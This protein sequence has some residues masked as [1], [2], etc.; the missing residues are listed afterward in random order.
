[1]AQLNES[2][3]SIRTSSSSWNTIQPM[4]FRSIYSF[5]LIT[6][7][8]LPHTSKGI[9]VPIPSIFWGITHTWVMAH[10]SRPSVRTLSSSW[11]SQTT[12]F[13]PILSFLVILE[14]CHS[15]WYGV[16]LVSRIDLSIGLFWKEP[17]KK[18]ILSLLVI[19]EYCHS[20]WYGVALVS[21]ID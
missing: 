3:P 9:S 21:R 18:T 11:N 13:R 2:R 1:M 19:I 14:Y 20:K 17:C 8:A 15:K 16:A 4:S 12:S 5:L 7:K 10:E 6:G